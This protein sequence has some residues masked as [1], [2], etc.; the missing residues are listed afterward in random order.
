MHVH[1]QCYT[2]WAQPML[3]WYKNIDVTEEVRKER[4]LKHF[5]SLRFKVALRLAVSQS[6][7]QYGLVSS[8]LWD[9]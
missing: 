7:S 8:P 6:V 5:L 4:C 3:K 1:L 9:L 2:T